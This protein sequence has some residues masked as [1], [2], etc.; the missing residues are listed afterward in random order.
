MKFSVRLWSNP[1]PAKFDRLQRKT[2]MS[3]HSRLHTPDRP[4]SATRCIYSQEK[5]VNCFFNNEIK[6]TLLKVF[7]KTLR[8][9]DNVRIVWHKNVYIVQGKVLCKI[10]IKS[11]RYTLKVL[12]SF[13]DPLNACLFTSDGILPLDITFSLDTL[14]EISH[15]LK[16]F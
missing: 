8:Y 2:V 5:K 10:D 3:P 7:T 16:Y 13:N 15:Y 14:T 11:L 9:W 4:R 6:A 12:Q 1:S